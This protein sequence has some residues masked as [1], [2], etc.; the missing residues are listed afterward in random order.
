[1]SPILSLA[2][3]LQESVAAFEPEEAR[4]FAVGLA[5]VFVATGLVA[6][7]LAAAF[8]RWR[9]PSDRVFFAR[10]GFTHVGAVLLAGV[11]AGFG[12]QAAVSLG[13]LE[14]SNLFVSIAATAVLLGAACAVAGTYAHRLH[15]EKLA[16][17]GWRFD[18]RAGRALLPAVGGYVLL[19]PTLFGVGVLWAELAPRLGVEF[20]VQHVL[21]QAAGL[22]GGQRVVGLLLMAGLVPL[23]E[24]W[25]FRGFLQPLLVQNLRE[26][27]GIA[28]TSLVFAALH[29]PSAFLPVF[30]LALYLGWVQLQSHRLVAAWAVHAAHNAL[31][32]SLVWMIPDA[33]ELFATG[34]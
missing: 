33:A 17:L 16:A 9:V 7:P 20:E 15:P 18:R 13:G 34:S 11:L 27:G 3:L 23:L 25:L 29:G 28:V 31:T 19:V 2:T 5:L 21:A 26:T 1:M 4:R 8:L 6:A 32:L 24:E 30:C 14:L 12:L 22:T 10:W